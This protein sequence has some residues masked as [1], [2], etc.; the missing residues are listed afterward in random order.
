LR[1]NISCNTYTPHCAVAAPLPKE[2]PLV[3]GFPVNEPG[4]YFQTSIEY[5]SIIQDIIFGLVLTSGAGT[6]VSGPIYLYNAL[7]YHLESLSNSPSD[8]SFGL[9]IIPHFPPPSGISTT[10]HFIVIHIERALTSDLD[11]S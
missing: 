5:S 4:E 8:N 2:P 7:T 10:A 11:T 3:R 1:F 9:T 6:S